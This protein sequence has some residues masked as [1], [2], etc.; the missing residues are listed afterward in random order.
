[1]VAQADEAEASSVTVVTGTDEC[2][3]TTSGTTTFDMDGV[4]RYRGHISTCQPDTS[5]PRMNLPYEMIWETDCYPDRRCMMWGTIKTIDPGPDG[6][7]GRFMGW[8]DAIGATSSVASSEGYGAYEGL[9]YVGGGSGGDLSGYMKVNSLIYEGDPPPLPKP[10]S[11]RL[12]CLRRCPGVD[13]LAVDAG[14][15]IMGS[16]RL[17]GTA[18]HHDRLDRAEP[19]DRR[20]GLVPGRRGPHPDAAG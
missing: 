5:D 7:R 18:H 1:M 13:A 12:G 16:G 2:H 4:E 15:R 6:W 11:R 10:P 3:M 17:R 14:R 19:L 9:T 20:D 8:V